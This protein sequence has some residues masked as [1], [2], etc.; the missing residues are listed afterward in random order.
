M[1]RQNSANRNLATSWL[2]PL[3]LFGATAAGAEPYAVGDRLVSFTLA[4]QYDVEQRVDGAVEVIL[5]SP[6]MD[7]DK[8][9]KEALKD[10]EPGALQAR[11]TVY[12][13]NIDGMPGLVAKLF[14]LPSMRK[15]PYSMLLDRDGQAT[16][17]L[18]VDGSRATLIRCNDLEVLQVLFFDDPA[19]LRDALGV[20]P[21]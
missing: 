2:A 19:E 20:A 18:P 14:A 16:A 8:V 17:R 6:D 13:A 12:V 5:F 10:V 3:L 7:A 1:T 4:D 11:N 15:R 21:N 9:V